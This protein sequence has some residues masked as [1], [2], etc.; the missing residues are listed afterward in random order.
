MFGAFL[1]SQLGALEAKN[2]ALKPSANVGFGQ[3]LAVSVHYFL[4][5]DTP[6]GADLVPAATRI[7]ITTSI[8]KRILTFLFWP[9]AIWY[10]TILLRVAGTILVGVGVAASAGLLRRIAP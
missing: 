9:S 2:P 1:F 3:G 4:P 7:R 6:V 10:A 5:M 8:G